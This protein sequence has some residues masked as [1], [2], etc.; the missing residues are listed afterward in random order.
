MN[1]IQIGDKVLIYRANR[2]LP[3]YG[4]AVKVIGVRGNIIT[5]ARPGDPVTGM[6]RGEPREY[7]LNDPHYEICRDEVW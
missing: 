2:Y 1:D 4:K 3:L 5:I 6:F 7:S